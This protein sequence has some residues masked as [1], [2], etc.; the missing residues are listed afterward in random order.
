MGE[1]DARQIPEWAQRERGRDLEWIGENLHLFWPAA[2][3]G[4]EKEGRGAIIAD[5]TTQVKVG[6]GISH[7]F[8]YV[9]L[10]TLEKFNQDGVLSPLDVR[11]VSE[12]EPDWEFVTV[13]L[14]RDRES[15][16]RIGIPQARTQ[17]G[18]YENQ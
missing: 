13:L 3:L 16:Y 6:E 8:L 7:P 10:G 17:G 5:T 9:P 4:F 14:K 1:K 11:L 2:Q 12:Y 15:A 18:Y